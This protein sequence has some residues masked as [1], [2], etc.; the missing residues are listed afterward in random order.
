MNNLGMNNLFLLF[1]LLLAFSCK[2]SDQE[3]FIINVDNQSEFAID[4]M[5]LYPY[6]GGDKTS[7]VDSVVFE[8]I[9]ANSVESYNY[10]L[11]I[12]SHDGILLTRFSLDN[13]K[14]EKE[15][16]YFS[17]GGLLSEEFSITIMSDSLIVE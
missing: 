9:D 1:A 13:K 4:D 6:F 15:F 11:D 12:P 14:F 10:T 2:N 5:V 8:T 16:G 3:S 7:F 17:N